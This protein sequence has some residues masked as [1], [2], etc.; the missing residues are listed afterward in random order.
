MGWVWSVLN[1]NCTNFQSTISHALPRYA[2]QTILIRGKRLSL[3]VS[4]TNTTAQSNERLPHPHII[5]RRNKALIVCGNRFA[6]V[7]YWRLLGWGSIYRL[8]KWLATTLSH[9]LN[10]Q[11][12][13][14]VSRPVH[15]D[16]HCSLKDNTQFYN[17]ILS[18]DCLHHIQWV[19][20]ILT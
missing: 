3:V 19:D 14:I 16:N 4:N 6:G 9:N 1:R 8:Y 17:R 7:P 18:E 2:S 5:G 12:D 20:I 15:S 13:N 10:A 11:V